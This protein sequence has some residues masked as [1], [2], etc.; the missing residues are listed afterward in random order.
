MSRTCT[1]W[2]SSAKQAAVTRPTQ[3]APITP[4][5][6]RAVMRRMTLQGLGGAGDVD[7][8]PL[9]ER[10]EQRVGDP[11]HRVLLAPR[12]QAHA[13]A[14]VEELELAAAHLPRLVR[15]LDDRRVG[16]GR[17]LEAVIL[18]DQA[19]LDDVAEA[20]PAAPPRAADLVG[21]RRVDA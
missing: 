7:H 16:P 13:V 14:V 12:H 3:P 18:A 8:L 20:R 6:S 15:R 11:V 1:S 17:A 10:L 2:P 9:G 5:G 21:A 19:V 4:M